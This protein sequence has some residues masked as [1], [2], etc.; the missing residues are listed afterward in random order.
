MANK[1]YDNINFRNYIEEQG[2]IAVI[3]PRHMW[4]D[5]EVFYRTEDFQLIPLV[6]K[7]YDLSSDSLRYRFHPKYNE[8]RI[9]RIDISEDIGIFPKISK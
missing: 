6:Y 9:F 8:N 1:G 7:D 4:K 5:G 2:I 3:P